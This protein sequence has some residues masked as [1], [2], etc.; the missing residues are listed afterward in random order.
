MDRCTHYTRVCEQECGGGGGGDTLGGGDEVGRVDNKLIN[1]NSI[2]I[3]DG[4]GGGD[5]I[6]N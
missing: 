4:G 3:V 2:T 1:L 5:D 6:P